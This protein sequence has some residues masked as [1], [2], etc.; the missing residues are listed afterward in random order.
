[1]INKKPVLLSSR[2][3]RDWDVFWQLEDIVTA[4]IFA[5]NNDIQKKEQYLFD[6]GPKNWKVT[7][8]TRKCGVSITNKKYGTLSTDSFVM[9]KGDK[10][11]YKFKNIIR[12]LMPSNLVGNENAKK[13]LLEKHPWLNFVYE[14]NIPISFTKIFKHK[15][16]NP[17]K[18]LSFLYK[19]QYTHKLDLFNKSGL[20]QRNTLPFALKR[21]INLHRFNND[22]TGE[23]DTNTFGDT[24]RFAHCLNKK[25]D[26]SWSVNRFMQEHNEMQLIVSNTLFG[27]GDRP[28]TISPIFDSAIDLI[29][30]I[31]RTTKELSIEGMNQKHCVGTYASEIDKGN[32]V[33]FNYKGYTLQIGKSIPL[34]IMQFR[35]K[36]NASAPEELR[37]EVNLILDKINRHL[38]ADKSYQSI[39]L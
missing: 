12:H 25:V 7:D 38:I 8:V 26:M 22:L 18:A 35:G 19:C 34:S 37:D 33:I 30:G 20:I 39:S 2:P 32:C 14:Y 28:L 29:P 24:L 13:V 17:K 6:D 5:I 11:Y 9:Q 16:F 3:S 15:L 1:M 4:R 27:I 31:I 21:I 23:I 10:F 36:R